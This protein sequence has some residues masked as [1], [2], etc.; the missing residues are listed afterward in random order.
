MSNKITFNIDGREIEAVPGQTILEAADDAGIYI[1]RLCAKKGLSPHGSCRVCT[2]RVNGRPQAA[3]TQ[4]VAPG[5]NVENDT[6][7][8]KARSTILAWAWSG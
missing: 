1:P 5:M 4:P 7:E 8:M 3:C 2:V 6:P